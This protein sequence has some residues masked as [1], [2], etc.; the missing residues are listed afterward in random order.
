MSVL[1]AAQASARKRP[2]SKGVGR[3]LAAAQMLGLLLAS[4]A[5]TPQHVPT[6]VPSHVRTVQASIDWKAAGEELVRVTAGYLQTDT[7]NPPGNETR[8]AQYLGQIL[9][10]EG[11]P[12]EIAEFAP[13]RGTLIARLKAERPT[14]KPLCMLSHIDVV[15]ARAEL[16]PKDKGPLSGAVDADGT[17]WGRGALDM[18]GMGALELMTLVWLKRLGLPLQRDVLLLAVADE[19][20]DNQGAKLLASR[21]KDLD[22]GH[23]INEGGIGLADMLQKGQTVFA[24]SVAEKG[25]LWVEMTAH[26]KSGHGSTP[27]PGRAPGKLL[28]AIARLQEHEEEAHFDPS[29]TYALGQ[30]GHHLGGLKGWV[31]QR[32]FW[33]RHLA[34]GQL[35]EE[36]GSKAAL[37][38]TINVTGL[39]T[40]EHEP[41]V[42]PA[43]ASA[44][45]DC[46]LLPG[47]SPKAFLRRLQQIVNDPTITWK[48]LHEAS[49]NASPWQDPFYEALVR[50]ATDGQPDAVAGPVLS[51]GF[52]DSLLL[53][54]L[55]VRAYGLVPFAISRALAETM[56]GEN[57]R[58]PVA[59]LQRGLRVL[60]SAVVDVA[61]EPGA[62]RLPPVEP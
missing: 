14:Q 37:I 54:P 25:L 4:C 23:L 51:V 35:M 13:G 49:A 47:V 29:L 6:P 31:L 27:L 33:L 16:W 43:T 28:A 18:K 11:I 57:E 55:G 45:L 32:P 40:G 59:A 46:R 39:N 10:K 9:T 2:R 60:L 19:E 34:V 44:K 22:C 3:L 17:L 7:T 1:V 42:V 58:V 20:V 48:V 62:V 56:H 30:V 52:T 53:R 38:N 50:H 5:V 12:Y 21:W 36:P 26:G 15:P 61:V 41:N 24:V 8:G